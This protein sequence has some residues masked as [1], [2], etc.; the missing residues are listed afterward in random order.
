M[1][2]EQAVQVES[3]P[4]E[5]QETAVGAAESATA[6]AEQETK[7]ETSEKPVEQPA[8][9]AAKDT[10]LGEKGKAELIKLRK[11]AQ[12]AEKQAAYE[13]G[14]REALESI[15]GKTEPKTPETYVVPKPVQ[16]AEEPYE[17]YLIRVQDWNL[18]RRE[19]Q[20][21]QAAKNDEAA[22]AAQTVAEKAASHRQAGETKYEDFY[23]VVSGINMPEP[24]LRE[25]IDSEV[26][27]DLAYYFGKN[28]AELQRISALPNNRQ[29]KEIARLEDKLKAGAV[30]DKTTKAPE[31]PPIVRAST[32]QTD[33][34][35]YLDD[36]IS[37]AERIRLSQERKAAR[38]R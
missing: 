35:R 24:M 11:R 13:R 31:P 7:T 26:G 28:P 21:M 25:V 27:H 22:K 34:A 20:R 9:D 15:A 8:P 32:V 29:I 4:T 30:V 33:E 37:P 5:T 19:Y 38:G 2:D 18:D 10:E 17:D 16:G 3:A 6:T 12:E 36:N 14:K 1:P 23:E